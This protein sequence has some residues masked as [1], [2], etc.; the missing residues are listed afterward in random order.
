M[1]TFAVFLVVACAFVAA[2]A[3]LAPRAWRSR[4]PWLYRDIRRLNAPPAG[5]PHVVSRI[6]VKSLKATLPKRP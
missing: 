4:M 5:G 6:D 2:F 3:R 1:E